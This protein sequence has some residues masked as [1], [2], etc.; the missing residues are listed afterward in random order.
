[1][2]CPEMRTRKIK[3]QVINLP[4]TAQVE[5]IFNLN[6]N[7]IAIAKKWISGWGSTDSFHLFQLYSSRARKLVFNF[8]GACRNGKHSIDRLAASPTINRL[9]FGI[10]LLNDPHK[11]GVA[12]VCCS[13][14]VF[15]HECHLGV[16]K[17]RAQKNSPQS[18]PF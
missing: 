5:P 17:M 4:C 14:K 18:V 2:Q 12:V 8:S 3:D 11:N 6:V 16:G 10:Q 13:R 1:M 7:G 15:N 9:S